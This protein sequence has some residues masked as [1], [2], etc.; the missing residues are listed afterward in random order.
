MG[1][2]AKAARLLE[3]A[4]FAPDTL[5][6]ALREAGRAMAFDHCWLVCA[7]HG[8][9][10]AP[11]TERIADN[12]VTPAD[13]VSVPAPNGSVLSVASNGRLRLERLPRQ[14]GE[15]SSAANI[16]QQALLAEMP[17]CA[18]WRFSFGAIT[19][20][21]ALARS[22]ESGPVSQREAE[23]LERL[24]PL[25]NRAVLIAHQMRETHVRGLFEGLSA[26]KRAAALLDSHGRVRMLTPPAVRLFGMDFCIRDRRLWSAHAPS[27]S[28]LDRLVEALRRS[29]G[30]DLTQTFLI[31]R[32]SAS[33]PVLARPVAIS[34]VGFDTLTGAR[35]ALF[36]ATPD[37]P[38]FIRDED[39]QLLFGLSK[40][41]AQITALL[42]DGL[43]L[44]QIADRRGVAVGT[45]RVQMKHIFQKTN[46]RRQAE[47]IKVVAELREPLGARQLEQP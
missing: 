35:L 38:A 17:H 32:F 18:W 41:E 14:D 6:E 27:Q 7:D 22:A 20:T 2:A 11:D 43:E 19:W 39:L 26:S 44:Q 31:Q 3:E 8:D 12:R 30:L 4:V 25:A 40:A 45:I 46:V 28:L 47:L 23:E 5:S 13:G 24:M 21:L 15:G 34:G 37:Q 10:A 1:D 29:D 16:R 9:S 42:A 33:R 36:F